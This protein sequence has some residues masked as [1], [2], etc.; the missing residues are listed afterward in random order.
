MY[1]DE[2]DGM[3]LS[4]DVPTL[5]TTPLAS[6]GDPRIFRCPDGNGNGSLAT[7]DYGVNRFALGVVLDTIEDPSSAPLTM[8]IDQNAVKAQFPGT[9]PADGYLLAS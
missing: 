4:G 2:N 3:F 1:A 5:W 7:P 6:Y 9:K 8:D